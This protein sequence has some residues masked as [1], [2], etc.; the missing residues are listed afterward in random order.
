MHN[1]IAG[2]FQ[3]ALLPEHRRHLLKEGLIGVVVAIIFNAPFVFLIFASQEHI[4]R[5]GPHGFAFDFLPQTFM[6]VLFT[7][8][9]LTTLTRRRVRTGK[10]ASCDTSLSRHLPR[11]VL[12]RSVLIAALATCVLAGTAIGMTL[13]LWHGPLSFAKVLPLKLAYA[14]VI[15]LVVPPIV[16]LAALGEPHANG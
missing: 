12:A 13:L 9:A 14:G 5:W 1:K 11:H 7:A 4:E 2:R 15:G 10:I 3:G 16:I 8:I 6:T